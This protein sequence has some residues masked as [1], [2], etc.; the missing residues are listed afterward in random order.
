MPTKVSL[1]EA[2]TEISRRASH[3][4]DK[5]C[6]VDTEVC[7]AAFFDYLNEL[8]ADEAFALVSKGMAASVRRKAR[9]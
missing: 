1:D 3:K 6:K 9:G 4:R 8:P 5:L 2:T 7:L